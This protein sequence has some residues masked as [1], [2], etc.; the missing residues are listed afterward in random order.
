MEICPPS[1]A[2]AAQTI[3]QIGLWRLK[4][5]LTQSNKSLE[6]RAKHLTK[7]LLVTAF[8][9]NIFSSVK[10]N[11]LLA[12]RSV[13]RNINLPYPDVSA[14]RVLKLTVSTVLYMELT[15]DHPKLSAILDN[16]RLKYLLQF[17]YAFLRISLHLIRCR[18]YGLG[19]DWSH[20]A[21]N[22]LTRGCTRLLK[23][24]KNIL[25]RFPTHVEPFHNFPY[26]A[27]K[28]S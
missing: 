23:L 22:Q 25:N 24:S 27:R 10:M 12:A 28:Q 5:P 7:C 11:I 2:T 8:T 16:L 4:L 3:N 21:S 1:D 14:L 19:A 13:S 15:V 26:C 6:L 18:N 20:S 9:V 17:F